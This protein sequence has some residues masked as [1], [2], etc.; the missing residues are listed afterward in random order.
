MQLVASNYFE[1]G[2]IEVCAG[3]ASQVIPLLQVVQRELA[4]A[5]ASGRMA[6]QIANRTVT[7]I[8]LPN[9]HQLGC[10]LRLT[11]MA[12]QAPEVNGW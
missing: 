2:T 5:A 10:W 9:E 1:Q 4:L 11:P 7:I 8:K 12:D 6:E 3:D